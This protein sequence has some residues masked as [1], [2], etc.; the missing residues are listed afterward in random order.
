MTTYHVR[1][2]DIR[3]ISD[4]ARG[5]YR[6]RWAAGGREHCKSFATKALADAFLTT[7]KDAARDGT[8]FDLATGQPARPVPAR[9]AVSWY[10]HARAYSQMKWP[11]LAAKS[12]RSVAE[13]L[14][15]ITLALT[16]PRPRAPGPDLL[17]R[18]LF[19]YAFNAASATRPVPAEITRALDWA[20]NASLPVAALED[21]DTIR[22]V[23]SACARRLD[24]RPAAAAT[25]RRKRA[26]LASALGYAVERRLLPASPLS[27]LQWKAAEVA[28]TVDRRSVASPAQAARLLAAVRQQGPRGEHMEA[29]FG[30]LYYAAL[31]PSEAVALRAADLVL[32]D[33]GWGRI[34]L[35]ASCPRAGTEW[36]DDGASRQERGLKHR[37][38][39]ETRSIPIPP[40]L[41]ELLRNHLK[42]YGTGPAGRVFRTARGG[43]LNDTG[44]GEVWERARPIAL[45]P[46]QQATPLARRPYDLRHA[47]VSLWLNAGVP[48]TEAARRAGHGVAVLLRVYANCIDGQAG[49]ANQRIGDAL[50]EP[51]SD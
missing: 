40:A 25:S 11:D 44:Y 12:R 31:R 16:A 15:T 45:T 26:V 29:F 30:C 20:A 24:G 5:R 18:A 4:T 2:W 23:L 50:E 49:P 22:A 43:P 19:G 46:A 35:A 21:P 1:F 10:D 38:P 34:D 6:V 39:G 27:Q 47:A 37:P 9:A 14:T 7:L 51:G 3:K 28:Q 13:A 36:T 42:R 8:P 41:V 17:R 33:S 32:P 48:A